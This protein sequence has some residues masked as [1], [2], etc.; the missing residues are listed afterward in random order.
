MIKD[1]FNEDIALSNADV[2]VNASNGFGYMGG[3]SG[4]IT[5]K[6]G[7]AE[8]I[9]YYSS[10]LVE[11]LAMGACQA[12]GKLGYFA[13]S[14]FVTAAPGMN[15]KYILHAVTM[16]LPGSKARLRTIKKLVPKIVVKAEALGAKT[17]AI[18]M[19]GAGT[20]RLNET[21]VYDIFQQAFENSSVE[22]LVYRVHRIH[23]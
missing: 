1:V 17:V 8:S 3:N 13:G 11:A 4:L 21:E 22:Y 19:L 16:W 15:C 10:G 14:V 20:G 7:V 9:H 6:L 23:V 12:K 2:I 18:P 5:R